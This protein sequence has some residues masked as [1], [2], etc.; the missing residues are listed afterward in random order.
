MGLYLSGNWRAELARVA[1]LRRLPASEVNALWPNSGGPGHPEARLDPS[2]LSPGLGAT[3]A[4][5]LA[6]LPAFPD[7][8]TQPPTASNEWAVDGRHSSTG[9]PLLAGDPHLAFG[10][11]GIWY[12]ARIETPGRV[13]AGATAPGVPFLVLGHN[14]RIAWTFTTTG[15]DVQDLFVEIP[16]GTG[17]YQTPDGPRP[18]TTRTERIHVRGAPDE[19]LAVRETRHG[20][21][22]SDLVAPDGPVLALAMANLA[23]GDTAASG[24]QALNQA[25]DVAAAGRAAALLTSPVQNLLVADRAGIGLFVTGRVPIRESRR[26]RPAGARRRRR[27]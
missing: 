7:R 19:T 11:P 1:L 6:A 12:L 23:P 10:M 13:L 9:A 2:R 21:V 14:S 20:P 26:R 3:A 22:I 25:D 5:L 17:M 8:F 18:F 27:A 4:K 24:L 16:V 15:A